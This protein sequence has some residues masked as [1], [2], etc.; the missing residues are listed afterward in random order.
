MIRQTLWTRL[1]LVL[2]TT[3][4]IHYAETTLTILALALSQLIL[5]VSKSAVCVRALSIET[6]RS[7]IPRI[8]LGD[9]RA[10]WNLRAQLIIIVGESAAITVR[11]L[12][13]RGYGPAKHRTNLGAGL[14]GS[15]RSLDSGINTA[16]RSLGSIHIRLSTERNLLA[17]KKIRDHTVLLVKD[18]LS[19]L[20]INSLTNNTLNSVGDFSGSIPSGSRNIREDINLGGSGN[21]GLLGDILILNRRHITDS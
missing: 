8:L 10:L 2:P 7:L 17:V 19:L 14:L 20:D 11:A 21:L 4:P 9:K 6:Q 15:P 5:A 12:S 3:I 18:G 13:T 16:R 1:V